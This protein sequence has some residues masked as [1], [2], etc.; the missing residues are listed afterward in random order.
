MQVRSRPGSYFLKDGRLRVQVR[1]LQ[2]EKERLE[3]KA[4][5]LHRDTLS[6]GGAGFPAASPARAAAA[7]GW[8][9]GADVG[10]VLA[11]PTKP[12]PIQPYAPG[13]ANGAVAG[14]GAGGLGPLL[15]PQTPTSKP[16]RSRAASIR[17]PAVQ[18]RAEPAP[19]RPETD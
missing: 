8:G 11:T 5:K 6:R 15:L 1:Q 13:R 14:A 9:L 17:V 4:K 10:D 18:V 3:A 19:G 7:A 2:G 16:P 12:R